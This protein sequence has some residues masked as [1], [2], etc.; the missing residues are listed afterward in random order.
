MA[1]RSKE[2]ALWAVKEYNALL[3]RRAAQADV[4]LEV[5]LD[6][7]LARKERIELYKCE[8]LYT[9]FAIIIHTKYTNI[10]PVACTLHGVHSSAFCAPHMQ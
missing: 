9:L 2:S 7:H 6:K 10:V 4:L 8:N 3:A 5:N 1:H